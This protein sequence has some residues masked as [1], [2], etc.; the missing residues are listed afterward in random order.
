MCASDPRHGRYLT[1]SAMFRGRIATKEV[2]EQLVLWL[3]VL[4]RTNIQQHLFLHFFPLLRLINKIFSERVIRAAL[5]KLLS[6]AHWIRG[7]A[8]DYTT[9]FTLKGFQLPCTQMWNNF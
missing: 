1:A 9:A 8:S 2:D 3:I 6:K 5:Y 4:F 7:G